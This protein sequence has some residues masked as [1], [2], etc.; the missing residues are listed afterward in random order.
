MVII[1]FD[2]SPYKCHIGG[3]LKWGYCT[4]IAGWLF[5]GNP[6]KMDDLGIPPF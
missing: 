3:F 1:G 5:H 6:L 4:P 2:P